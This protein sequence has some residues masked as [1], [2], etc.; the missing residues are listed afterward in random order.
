[1]ITDMKTVKCN[2]IFKFAA[3]MLLAAALPASS[4]PGGEKPDSLRIPQ[5]FHFTRYRGLRTTVEVVGVNLIMTAFGR[6]IME[7]DGSGFRVT[8]ESIEENLRAGM[9][10]DDNTFSAN[11]FRHPYQG[12]M[13]FNAARANGYDFYQS[14]AFS[15]LGAW[16]WEYTGE[17]HHPAYNDW[18]NTAVGGI[19]VGEALWRLSDM[20][21]DNQAR[22]SDRTW[23]EVG[24]LLI[25]PLRGV[26]RL[27]TGEAFT[28]HQNAP[29][30]IP[31]YFGGTFNVGLRILGD[32][33]RWESSSTKVFISSH[34]VY[35]TKPGAVG[36]K[37]FDYFDF[38]FQVNTQ[39]KPHGLG[40]FVINA[41]LYG[42]DMGQS[43]TCDRQLNANMHFTYVD[44][45]A[46]TYGGQSLSASYLSRFAKGKNYESEL[47]FN[48]EGIILGAS[49]SDYF[50]LS[51]REYDYGPGIGVR[52]A[53]TL[54]AGNRSALKAVYRGS[55]IHSINGTVADHFDNIIGARTDFT[56]RDWFRLGVEYSLFFS[57]RYYRDYP[58]VWA[59]NPQL[60]VY[61]SW[62]FD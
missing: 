49:K 38:G 30:R 51:N 35:G 53:Y 21:V 11:N 25:N 12:S 36:G 32:E 54:Y 46:Y 5:D 26:N 22:G 45:E 14:G 10:W 24:G 34:M 55:W 31:D 56:L 41:M 18:V 58:D 4:A 27:V 50:N 61:F 60:Q 15:F 2:L 57:K 9:E 29:G 44:N 20:V 52:T 39:N 3:V 1:M 48:L 7:P 6:Y 42:W 62:H 43:D 17:R 47:E 23:R 40:L 33:D 28:V 8:W 37:P 16:L 19:S 59:R 13:Y